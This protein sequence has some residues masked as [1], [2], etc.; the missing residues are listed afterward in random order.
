MLHQRDEQPHGGDC[1]SRV[2]HAGRFGLQE[3]GRDEQSVSPFE[4]GCSDGRNMG[5]SHAFDQMTSERRY[6]MD[7]T[8]DFVINVM[9]S[10]RAIQLRRKQVLS[11]KKTQPERER[12]EKSRHVPPPPDTDVENNGDFSE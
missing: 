11:R 3:R 9:S 1:Q 6:A 8:K 4:A 7:H 12:K 5:Y 10:I 2:W